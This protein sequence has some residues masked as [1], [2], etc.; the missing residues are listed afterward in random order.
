MTKNDTRCVD[1]IMPN[2]N[3]AKYL[4]ASIKSV[5]NQT[6][7][8]WKL[9][10]IDDRSNDNSIELLKKY[11]NNKKIK[12]IYLK[13][14][15]GPSY[16]R[17]IGLKL[18]QAKIICFL[19]SDDYWRK[20]KIEK[21]LSFLKKYNYDFIYSDYYFKMDNIQ[22]K[23]NIAKYFI[24]QQFILN[25]AINTSTIMIKKKLLKKIKFRNSFLEDYIFKCEILKKGIKAYKSNYISAYY[26]QSENSRSQNKFLNLVN[27]FKVNKKYLKLNFFTNIKSILLISI[28]YFKKYRIF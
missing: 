5:I 7:K 10:I 14:N 18:S 3:K 16:C 28:N 21:Q 26:N 27:L 20:F 8:S 22:R 15:K 12:I 13:K 6:Y 2:Y 23:T 24:F 25:S 19:D 17:N 9:Y 11:K 1:V 4:D